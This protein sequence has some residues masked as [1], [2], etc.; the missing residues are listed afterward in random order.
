MK[1]V[2]ITTLGCKTNQ[3]ESAAIV[4]SVRNRGYLIVPFSEFAD[5]YIINT[6]TVTSKSDA[7]SRRLIRRARRQNAHARIVVTGCYAQLAHEEIRT[8]PGVTQV[9][10]NNEKKDIAGF[11][12]KFEDEPIVAVSGFTR[13]QQADGVMLESFAEHTRA[14]LQVQNG[15]DAYCSYCIVP[16]VR[17]PSRSVSLEDAVEGV[18]RFVEKGFKEIVLTGIHL[19]MYGLDLDPPT[20]LLDLLCAIEKRTSVTRLRIGS[21]E[22]GEISEELID[23]LSTSRICCPHLHIPLQSGDDRV[24]SR[25]NRD[26]SLR[27]YSDVIE[28]L[29][30]AIPDICIGTDVIVGF[31][32]E[33]EQEFDNTRSYLEFLP[34]AYFHVFPFSPRE[35]TL[36][37]K[38]P[39]KVHGAV[40]KERVK[41]L[42]KLSVEKK[43]IY[44]KKFLGKELDVLVQE[45]GPGDSCE[46][47]SRNYIPVTFNGSTCLINSEV[48]GRVREICQGFV[49]CDMETGL[50]RKI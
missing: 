22:P 30:T 48:R 40:I 23:F 4:E 1:K 41:K 2:A 26:Y 36:A 18:R 32:G 38:M 34:L 39:N 37:A 46:G 35:Q 6:C 49:Y 11:I 24:L 7:E 43:E 15:C 44:F 19:G 21:L 3:F 33:S 5:I 12:E 45:R 16:F 14:F 28:K 29:L 27:A 25:M 42:R 50:C 17:G 20:S 9:L 13:N 47:L 10:G 8:F 31:P